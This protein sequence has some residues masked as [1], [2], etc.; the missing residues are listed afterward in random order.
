MN[1]LSKI[2]AKCAEENRAALTIFTTAGYPDMNGSEAAI[3]TAIA[4]GADIIELGVPFSDPMADGPAVSLA[5]RIAL[6]NGAFLAPILDMAARIRR[7]HPETGLILFSYLNIMLQYGYEKLAAELA[8]L[9]IDAILAID[10]PLSERRELSEICKKYDLQLIPIITAKTP[11]EAVNAIADSASM[12]VF[13]M[14]IRGISHAAKLPESAYNDLSALREKL[15]IPLAVGFGISDTIT[16]GKMARCA[17]S[18]I[19][20][21]AFV[22]ALDTP[23]C[24]AALVRD[25]RSAM[26]R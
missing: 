11:P 6:E 19:I 26:K 4:E 2:Y 24:A 5:S 1:R 9:D 23:G 12:A 22:K 17:D 13:S 16:A 14:N 18:V 3:E 10:M 15:N 8:E 25:L 7:R 21:G 20:G